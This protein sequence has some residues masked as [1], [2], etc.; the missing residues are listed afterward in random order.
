M[1]FGQAFSLSQRSEPGFVRNSTLDGFR[2][3]LSGVTQ[4]RT[5][6]DRM[7]ARPTAPLRIAEAFANLQLKN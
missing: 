1:F 3:Q 6:L 7:Y 5:Y 2:H 4:L